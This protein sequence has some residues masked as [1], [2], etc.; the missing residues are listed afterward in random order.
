MNN[1]KLFI[2]VILMVFL[3]MIGACKSVPESGSMQ[4]SS[5]KNI[6]LDPDITRSVSDKS[7]LNVEGEENG[8]MS[9]HECIEHINHRMQPYLLLLA[10]QKHGKGKGYER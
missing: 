10:Q 3:G 2:I 8:C 7:I 4:V 6:T 5:T 9:C 1:A